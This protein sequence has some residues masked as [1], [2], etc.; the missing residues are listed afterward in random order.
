MEVIDAALP[1]GRRPRRA[2]VLLVGLSLGGYL[3]IEY[4]ARHPIASTDSWPH[5][6]R[7][8]RAAFG[9]AGYRAAGRG[10][11]AAARPRAAR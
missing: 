4:A 3:A 2:P 11:R 9:L 10:D 6:L 8:G 5:L 1:R 7:P